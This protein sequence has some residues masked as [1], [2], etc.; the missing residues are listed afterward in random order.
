MSLRI[1]AELGINHQGDIHVMCELIRQAKLHGADMV[2][3][4]LY[5]SQKLLGD[6]SRKHLEWKKLEFHDL[7]L[8]AERVDIPLFASVFDME[9]LGWCQ[10][11][12]VTTVKIPHRVLDKDFDLA[13]KMC[14]KARPSMIYVSVVE[15][16]PELDELTKGVTVTILQA[17]PLYPTLAPAQ[18]N[19][20]LD[21]ISD[22]TLGISYAL[23]AIAHGAKVV[24]KHF[25][26][27][28]QYP[29]TTGQ[30]NDHVFSMTPDEL[31]ILNT[32]GRELERTVGNL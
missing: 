24:E 20:H 21:G 15:D 17:T 12:G 11:F 13:R 23:Y 4:Q 7:L 6:D 16:M 18:Y 30:A 2:K 5:D 22:H 27:Q 10:E 31:D 26:L 3:V 1:I 8:Y 29:G 28:K 14:L 25:A 19:Y 32:Y 9:R